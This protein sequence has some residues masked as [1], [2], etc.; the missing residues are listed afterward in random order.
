MRGLSALHAGLYTLPL[1]VM[2][3]LLAPLSGWI[4]GRRG[5]RLPLVVAG[6]AMTAGGL[7]LTGL[8][9]ATSRRLAHDRLRDRS[10][11]GPAW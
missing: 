2:T 11:S 7:L 10:A 4:I 6:V 3:L 9:P 5:P 8:T 1:A